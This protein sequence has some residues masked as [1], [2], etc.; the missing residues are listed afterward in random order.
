MNYISYKSVLT[1]EFTFKFCNCLSIF[2]ICT[3]GNAGYPNW[4]TDKSWNS[5]YHTCWPESS[6]NYQVMLPLTDHYNK[7]FISLPILQLVY[8][9]FFTSFSPPHYSFYNVIC[10]HIL[11]NNLNKYFVYFQILWFKHEK[12]VNIPISNIRSLKQPK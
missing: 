3:M 12:H 11:K 9:Y 7:R 4:E 6:L 8:I 10:L 5:C 1:F 2:S